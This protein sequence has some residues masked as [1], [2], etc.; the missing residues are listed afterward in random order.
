M[1]MRITT[2]ALLVVAAVVLVVGT[3]APAIAGAAR[4]VLASVSSDGEHGNHRSDFAAFSANGRYVAFISTSWNFFNGDDFNSPDVFVHDLA[5]LKTELVSVSSD[6]RSHGTAGHSISWRPA[7]SGDGRFVAFVGGDN[8]VPGD[9]NNEWDVFVHDREQRTTSR[10]SVSSEGQQGNGSSSGPS[11]SADGRFVAFGSAASNLVPGDTNQEYDAFVHDRETGITERISVPSDGGEGN[12][13]SG[14]AAISADGRWVAF[15]SSASNLH[16]SDCNGHSYDVFLHDRQTGETSMVTPCARSG[17]YV[18]PA[19]SAEGR[20]VAFTSFD[21]KRVEGDT[22]T[23]PDVFVFERETGTTERVSVSSSGEQ[24][25]DG[26][27]GAAI[28]DDGRYVAFTSFATNLVAND[29]NKWADVFVRDRQNG[30]TQR[31]SVSSKGE[32]ARYGSYFPALSGDGRLVVFH[33]YA[34]NFDPRDDHDQ[35]DV[36]VHGLPL[37]PCRVEVVGLCLVE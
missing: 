19:I 26:S 37:P 10:I 4:T 9:T 21:A 15:V 36:Y 32:Q 33:S 17:S 5:T 23:L 29:T 20:H 7:I 11:I 1:K 3:G 18:R 13:D 12:R 28:S 35:L 14:D 25:N 2:K 8:L 6:G 22:N 34:T 24:A 16:A 27:F 30:T 31:E